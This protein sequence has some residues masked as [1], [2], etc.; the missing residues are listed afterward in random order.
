MKWSILNDEIW[1]YD[2]V[3]RKDAA[4]VEM[5]TLPIV[6][7]PMQ[8]PH[9]RPFSRDSLLRGKLHMLQRPAGIGKP[10]SGTSHLQWKREE[11]LTGASPKDAVATAIGERFGHGPMHMTRS[12]SYVRV[13]PYAMH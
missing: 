4:A 2:Q 5:I 3:V 12:L 8:R 1:L 10:F 11:S 7:A 6:R 9:Q 13:A